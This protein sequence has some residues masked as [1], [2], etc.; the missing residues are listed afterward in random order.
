MKMAER[1][2]FEPPVGYKPTHAFQA[3]ALNHSATSPPLES[4]VP[5]MGWLSNEFPREREQRGEAGVSIKTKKPI[6]W[7]GVGRVPGFTPLKT[8]C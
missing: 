1:G 5:R 6:N 2:G 7:F 4:I 8:V 3:C